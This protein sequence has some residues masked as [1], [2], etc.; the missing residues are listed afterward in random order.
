M[1]IDATWRRWPVG[2]LLIVL[3]FSSMPTTQAQVHLGPHERRTPICVA[4]AAAIKRMPPTTDALTW[5]EHLPPIRGV[6][7]PVW[8]KLDPLQHMDVLRASVFNYAWS[9]VR[10][11]E[12]AAEHRRKIGAGV[13]QR[14]LDGIKDGSITLEETSVPTIQFEDAPTLTEDMGLSRVTDVAWSDHTVSGPRRHPVENKAWIIVVK[15]LPTTHAYDLRPL[16]TVINTG[17]SSSMDVLVVEGRPLFIG[18]PE[19]VV[20]RHFVLGNRFL[21]SQIA[22]TETASPLCQ[23]LLTE[24]PCQNG[25]P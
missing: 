6:T 5:T 19:G 7:R 4:L 3:L 21:G 1:S 10:H 17:V 14:L 24:R 25:R 13:E 16:N 8:S 22:S 11:P 15:S 20:R 23:L 12:K 2:P 18:M 9:E